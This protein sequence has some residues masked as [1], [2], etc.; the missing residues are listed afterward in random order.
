MNSDTSKLGSDATKTGTRPRGR[1]RKPNVH[2]ASD[3]LSRDVIIAKAAQLAQS[4]PLAE[5]SMVR[6]AREFGVVPGLIHYYVGS[7]DE[8]LS[9]VINIYF[10][11]RVDNMPKPTGDWREDIREIARTSMRTMMKYGGVAQYIATH[12]RF[13]LF[14]RVAKG[15][16]DY[17]LELFNCVAEIFYKGGLSAKAAAIGYH[18]LTQFV[19]SSTV[20]EISGLSPGQH[21]KFI[22]TQLSDLD[23]AQYR[24]ANYIA[25]EFSSLQFSETFELGL[26]MLIEGISKLNPLAT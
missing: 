16:T 6:L 4:E 13:R 5:L 26:E 24:G 7:R 15:E 23:E 9:G 8:L 2:A 18:L 12:N 11:D 3:G 19:V 22:L 17:G 20:S 21:K 1:P 10:K 25:D 14:Q